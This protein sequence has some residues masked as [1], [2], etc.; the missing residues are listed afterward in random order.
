MQQQYKK[1]SEYSSCACTAGKGSYARLNRTLKSACERQERRFP[2]AATEGAKRYAKELPVGAFMVVKCIWYGKVCHC[3]EAHGKEDGRG[4]YAA[5]V[6][7]FMEP[8]GACG[9]HDKAWE[10]IRHVHQ[11]FF[12]N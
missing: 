4:V 3:D 10:C 7:E 5:S 11:R 1:V 9:C 12:C 8:V 2:H 6:G